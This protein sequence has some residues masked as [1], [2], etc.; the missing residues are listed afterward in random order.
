MRLFV[1]A[2]WLSGAGCFALACLFPAS[3]GAYTPPTHRPAPPTTWQRAESD[4]AAFETENEKSKAAFQRVLDEYRAVYHDNP[5]DAHAADAV[6][7]VADL[8]AEQGR[9]LHDRRSSQAALG[10]YEFLRSQY[11]TSSMRARAPAGRRSCTGRRPERPGPRPV[12]DT[13]RCC[14]RLQEA[15][16]QPK[17]EALWRRL[18]PP[19]TLTP[20]MRNAPHLPRRPAAYPHPAAVGLALTEGNARRV[21]AEAAATAAPAGPETEAPPMSPGE[22]PAASQTTHIAETTSRRTGALAQVTG[23]R[24]WSTPT[25]TRGR[26]RSRR[27][28]H[29]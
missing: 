24:H 9:T 6:F 4:R 16:R 13:W 3:S 2:G 14:T 26:H 25:Y 21:E 18:M 8:L 5:A 19:P 20:R 23:I 7:A 22:T 28:G 29:V 15:L 27:C 1:R 10:Q 12:P 11:P 17:R